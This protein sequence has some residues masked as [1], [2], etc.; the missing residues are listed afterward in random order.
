MVKEIRSAAPRYWEN[1][2]NLRNDPAVV[3]GFI[4]KEHI[5]CADHHDFMIKNHDNFVL[6][7]V[8]DNFAGYGRVIDDD[9]SVC[10]RPEYQKMGVAKFLVKNMIKWRPNA[11]AKVKINNAASLALFESLGFKK[12]YYILEQQ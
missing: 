2:R 8:D 5:S 4:Q 12:K 11:F 10:V 1:I 9:I 6:C 7:F 3:D